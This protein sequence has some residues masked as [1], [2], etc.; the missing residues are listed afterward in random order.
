MFERCQSQEEVQIPFL[1][2]TRKL[3]LLSVSVSMFKFYLLL[4]LFL[5]ISASNNIYISSPQN[6]ECPNKY[7]DLT[8]MSCAD[9]PSNAISTEQ[10]SCK[11]K[12]GYIKNSDTCI[13]C[14]AGKVKITDEMILGL[15]QR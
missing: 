1:L 6:V 15:I 4:C 8:T 13:A 12:S 9:C 5:N 14:S 3:F 2:E 7:Y 11:C 10:N